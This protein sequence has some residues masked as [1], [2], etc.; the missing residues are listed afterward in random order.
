MFH[1]DMPEALMTKIMPYSAVEN[2]DV[3]S[4]SCD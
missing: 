3:A 4:I 1:L 2:Q